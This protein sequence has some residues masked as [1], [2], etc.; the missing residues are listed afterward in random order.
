MPTPE[1]TEQ[2]ANAAKLAESQVELNR[3]VQEYNDLLTQANNLSVGLT[4]VQASL[5]GLQADE[6]NKRQDIRKINEEIASINRDMVD[7]DATQLENLQR[8]LDLEKASRDVQN[9]ELGGIRERKKIA[10]EILDVQKKYGKEVVTNLTNAKALS[11][12]AESLLKKFAGGL[13]GIGGLFQQIFKQGKNL[14]ELGQGLEG[15]SQ[16]TGGKLGRALGVAGKSLQGLKLGMAG[17]IALGAAV[18]KLAIEFDNLSKEIGRTTGFGDK[19][20]K[21][22]IQG[23]KQTMTSGVS[24][25]EFGKAITG[26]ANNFS[27]FNPNAEKTNTTLSATASQLDKLGVGVDVSTKLM[28]H[29]HR[30]MG[31]SAEVAADMTAQLVMM[32]R[33]IGITTAKMASDFQASAGVLARYG[34]D[35]V[36]VFKQLAAQTKATGLEMGTLLGIADKFDK[37]DTAAD[38]AA[39]LNAVLGTQLSTLELMSANEAERV[40]MIRQQVQASVGNFDSLDKFTK[41]Y[42]AQAM[43]VKDVAEAQRLLNMSQAE[44]ARYAQGQRE[45]ADIQAELAAATR[46][47]VPLL[48]KLKIIGIKLF[49]TFEPL[50]FAFG[51]VFDVFELL[52]EQI[53]KVS[54]TKGMMEALGMAF[55]VLAIGGLALAAGIGWIPATIIAVVAAFGAFYDTMSQTIN[56]PFVRIFHFLSEGMKIM[57]TPMKI[58]LGFIEDMTNKFGKFFLIMSGNSDSIGSFMGAAEGNKF[59]IKAFAEL[60]T[61][62]IATGFNKV[63]SAVMELSNIKIDGFLAMSTT[64]DSSSFVMGSDGLIKSITEGK[65]IVDVKMPDMKLPDVLVKVFIGDKEL[66]TLIDHRIEAMGGAIG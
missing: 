3:R 56:P 14:K 38:S 6:L 40:D 33:E 36:E 47:L 4:D 39:Q 52:Y 35:N 43:G 5:A 30:T 37:F 22:L 20:N 31:V 44:A 64:G 34:K 11:G 13:P 59:D 2:L 61:S 42:V 9:D 51:A 55:K 25:A 28:D 45:Q 17:L 16:I 15:L 12:S 10:N 58:V 1:E 19:F 24:I 46:E 21:T 65:L 50:I 18:G 7:A 63:K 27:G 54:D 29:F 66:T 60:D 49:M 26:L 32:G 8:K 62:K 57:L 41:M 48:D 53:S 23:Y